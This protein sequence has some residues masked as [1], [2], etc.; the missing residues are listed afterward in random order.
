MDRRWGYLAGRDDERRKDLLLPSP[1]ALLACA[2]GGWGAARL[3]EAP[4]AWPEGWLL[5]LSDVTALLCSRWARGLGG[6]FM[7]H[8]SPPW[9][10]NRSG[11]R[12]D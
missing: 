10:A 6:G 7:D 2:R 11:A 9:R 8:Y 12:N 3:L 1:G 5:G 4:I